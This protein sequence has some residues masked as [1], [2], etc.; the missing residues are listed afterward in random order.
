ME[1]AARFGVSEI[2]FDRVTLTYIPTGITVP[3][4]PL[5]QITCLC[6]SNK[7]P[8]DLY[9]EFLAERK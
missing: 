2:A 3:D 8:R 7:F 9:A 5:E 4:M 6:L 1:R